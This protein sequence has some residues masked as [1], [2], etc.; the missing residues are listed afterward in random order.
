MVR[1]SNADQRPLRPLTIPGLLTAPR[2]ERN[3]PRNLSRQRD[4]SHANMLIVADRG[5]LE[6]LAGRQRRGLAL[7]RRRV[8]LLVALAIPATARRRYRV[9]KS[10]PLLGISVSAALLSGCGSIAYPLEHYEAVYTKT[11]LETP[12]PDPAR[13]SH[14]D[15]ARVNRGRYLVEIAGCGACHTDRALVGEPSA[16]RFLAG[17]HL[18]IAYTNPFHDTFS[19]VVYPSN[20]TPDPRTGLGNWNDAQIAAAIRSGDLG[21]GPGHLIVM[22]WPLYQHMTDDDVNAVVTYLRS[23]PAIEHQV[24]TRV[25]PGT[26]ATTPYVYFG[27]FRSGPALGIH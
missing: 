11:A 26:R 14:L 4:S 10:P 20:L 5:H 8:R 23:I 27:V 21:S 2:I 13:L 1:L 7:S 22:S 12:A 18:G 6:R 25:A 16:A 19:G 15:A 3:I 17:S 24:P 9:L